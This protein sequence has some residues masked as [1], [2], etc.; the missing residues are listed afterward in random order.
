MQTFEQWRSDLDTPTLT[1]QQIAQKHGV[2]VGIIQSQLQHGI[3]VEREHT[4]NDAIAREIALDHLAE[5]PDYYT[6]LAKIE[7]NTPH[8]REWGTDS[9]VKIYTRDTPGQ[10]TNRRK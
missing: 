7:E 4:S 8:D 5:R 3:Q 6:L 9:L 10:S 1:P 2:S